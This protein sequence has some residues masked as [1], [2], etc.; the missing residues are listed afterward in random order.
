MY[1]IIDALRTI[2][3]FPGHISNIRRYALYNRVRFCLSAVVT[4]VLLPGATEAIEVRRPSRC[5]EEHRYYLVFIG[6]D[7]T[8]T[9][10]QHYDTFTEAYDAMLSIK[11]F[12][13]I[14]LMSGHRWKDTPS[15]L[16]HQHMMGLI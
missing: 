16:A 7:E 12:T 4:H 8:H 6:F 15:F 3:E 9:L 14:E 1:A 11:S 2:I 13:R 5:S 10:S